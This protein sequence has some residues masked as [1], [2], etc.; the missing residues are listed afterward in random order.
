M[1]Y[2]DYI[3]MDTK[4]GNYLF[5]CF[6]SLL[7]DVFWMVGFCIGVIKRLLGRKK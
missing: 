2:I 6:L 7:Y 5:K 4:I 3:L 1:K